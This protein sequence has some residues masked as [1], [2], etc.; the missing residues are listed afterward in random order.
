MFKKSEKRFRVE[1]EEGY[2]GNSGNGVI[3]VIVDT[4]TGVHYIM[5]AGIGGSSITPLLDCNGN[6]VIDPPPFSN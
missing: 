1:E 3:Q 6:V 5:T 4:T 2:S